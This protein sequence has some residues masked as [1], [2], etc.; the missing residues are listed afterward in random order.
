M[1]W[2]T[3]TRCYDCPTARSRSQGQRD[4]GKSQALAGPGGS[5]RASEKREVIDGKKM[6]ERK[7]LVES[8]GRSWEGEGGRG[9]ATLRLGAR[10]SV[11]RVL[12]RMEKVFP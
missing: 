5:S 6:R 12:N 1:H 4:C 8:S 11:G 3:A 10:P 2:E 9:L 7:V